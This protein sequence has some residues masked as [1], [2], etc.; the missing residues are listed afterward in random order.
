[1]RDS[2]ESRRGSRE[3]S[4]HSPIRD[5]PSRRTQDSQHRDS[6]SGPSGSGPSEQDMLRVMRAFVQANPSMAQL[7]RNPET[8]APELSPATV[9]PELS[10]ATVAPHPRPTAAAPK[11]REGRRPGRGH[12]GTMDS[13]AAQLE[14][15]EDRDIHRATSSTPTPETAPPA[16]T[17]SHA[18]AAIAPA[19]LSV[20]PGTANPPA[21]QHS[22]AVESRDTTHPN[23]TNAVGKGKAK[24]QA[25]ASDP[26]RP[27]QPEHPISTTPRRGRSRRGRR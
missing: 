25:D 13:P 20:P 21:P 17:I 8:V 7:L 16:P 4:D 23:A 2:G 11:T 15:S 19:P 24:G 22:T 9:A 6:D 26:K 1:M 5:Q 10:A 3:E 18:L 27:D 14:S 12:D